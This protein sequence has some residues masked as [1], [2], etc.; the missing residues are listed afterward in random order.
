MFAIILSSD[1]AGDRLCIVA[2]GA[3][4]LLFDLIDLGCVWRM[5]RVHGVL[6]SHY[7]IRN[8]ISTIFMK[9]VG[10]SVQ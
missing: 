9:F 3:H 5:C 4:G 7:S 2:L 1:S 10:L 6:L 8:I